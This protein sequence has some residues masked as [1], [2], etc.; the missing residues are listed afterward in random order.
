MTRTLDL[1][2]PRP[3]RQPRVMM[4]MTDAGELPGGAPGASYKCTRCGFDS[5]WVATPF[6]P[7][8]GFRQHYKRPC[9]RCNGGSA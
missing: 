2:G 8:G 4:T 3:R 1:F 5:G 6:G 7:R 9:P